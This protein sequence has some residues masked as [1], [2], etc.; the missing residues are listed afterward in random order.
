VAY[1]YNSN[2]VVANLDS[3]ERIIGTSGSDQVYGDAN[4]NTF[5]SNGVAFNATATGPIAIELD[6]FDG[7]GGSDTIDVYRFSNYGGIWADLTYAGPQVWVAY[8]Q[9]FATGG[10][11][12]VAVAQ[13]T[14]VE[15]L[16]GTIYSDQFYGDGN[17]NTYF[18]NGYDTIH[19]EIFDGRGGMDTFD[20]SLS[21]WALWIALNYPAMEVWSNGSTTIQAT[22]ANSTY[23]VVDLVSVENIVGSQYADT[24]IGDGIAN[25][26]E[27]GKGNDTLVGGLGGDTFVFNFDAVNSVGAGT[28]TINDFTAGSAAGHDVIQI[29]GY[30]QNYDTFA[31][32]MLSATNTAGGV[33]IQL[34]DGSIDLLGLVKTQLTTDDFAFL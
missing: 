9:T 3:V 16:V 30:G 13:L 23:Q 19:S 6:R 10:N 15:N 12:N 11:A 4:D 14:A 31:E 24:L 22:G 34:Y 21:P 20:G 2:I 5:V 8:G 25:R 27:G 29:S 33:H 32:L 18:F 1:G 7:R 28:D 26:I 17:A